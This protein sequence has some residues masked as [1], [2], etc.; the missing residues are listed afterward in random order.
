MFLFFSATSGPNPPPRSGN[1]TIFIITAA[2]CF[3]VIVVILL[4]VLVTVVRKRARGTTWFPEGFLKGSVAAVAGGSG[5][6]PK[7]RRVPD[8]QEMK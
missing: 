4:G 3:I 8:G 6:K 2:A 7:N 1:Q 5:A